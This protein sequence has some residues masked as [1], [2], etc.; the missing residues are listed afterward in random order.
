MK[1]TQISYQL[2]GKRWIE[3]KIER[4]KGHQADKRYELFRKLIADQ[5]DAEIDNEELEE[6]KTQTYKEVNH[7]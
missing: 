6:W 5:A 2:D 1:I 7:G 4:D 3:G